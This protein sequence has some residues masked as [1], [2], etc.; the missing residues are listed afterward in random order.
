MKRPLLLSLI[1]VAACGS[2]KDPEGKMAPMPAPAPGSAGSGS[3]GS[4]SA[5]PAEPTEPPSP[6]LDLA[7]MDKTVP[8]GDDFFGYANGTWLR[9]TEIPADRSSWGSGGIT[10]EKTAKRVAELI[11]GAMTAPA[12]SEERKVGDYYATYMDEAAI[13]KAGVAPLK[14]ALDRIAGIKEPMH[15]ALAIGGTLRADVDAINNTWFETA[16]LFGVWVAQDLTD[17][18][19]Y[20]PFL[21]QGGLGMPSRDYYQDA[22]PKMAELRTKYQ[23]HIDAM[24]KLAGIA[25][26]D[27]LAPKIME[28]EV[29]IAKAHQPRSDSESVKNGITHWTRK[30]FDTKAPGLDWG[31]LFEGAQLGN[32]EMFDV[33]HPKATIGISA[34]AKSVP[35]DTWK[36]Y[37]TYRAIDRAA[38]MLPKA[39]V[40]ESFAFY[41]SALAGTPALAERWKRGVD[42]T[43]DAVGEAVGKMYVGKY[44]PAAAKQKI[45][46]MVTHIVAAFGRR[47]DQLAWMTPATKAKA[48]AKLAIIRVSVGYPDKF[49]DYTGLEIVKGD[50]L[51]NAE[52]ASLFEYKR[53]LAKLGT[54]VDRDEWVMTPQL[55]NA[56]NLPA[57]NAMNFPAGMLQ[58][59]YFD[60]T[61][62]SAMDY[63]AIGSVI[64]H[65]ISHSFDDQGALFDANGK[66]ENWWTKEDFAHFSASG[67]AL[68]KQFDAYKPFPDLAVNGK[69]TLSE[70][71][72]DVAGLSAAYDAYRTSLGGK[73]APAWEGLTGDQ[74]FFLAFGQA[75]R[76]K[77]REPALRRR[78]LTDGHAPGEYR[79]NT[80]RNLDAWY[81]AFDI[82]GGKL[83]LTPEQRVKIW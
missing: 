14:P 73:E 74:Q 69:Q 21:L 19:K 6:A 27:A 12:G 8:P 66:L 44:F 13:E 16:N 80:V 4:G 42:H 33:W 28:L 17:P 5:A 75:W 55:V 10:V 78:I 39:F 72:A 47:I 45:T 77:F 51:G 46:E 53:N 32:V 70:N 36:A 82:K 63:G 26:A 23:A 41:G 68:V 81:T 1:L 34:L 2:K 22:A 38:P 7:G 49:R 79:A 11:K 35:L 25:D 31:A 20:I 62:P 24:L 56:V 57:M 9:T 3:A 52:R 83:A 67:A 71:I 64:G 60:P 18:S 58:A 40:D 15:L 37:L 29:K 48:K 59:P 65:E 50:A 61:R 76:T 54:P 43:S 30:D